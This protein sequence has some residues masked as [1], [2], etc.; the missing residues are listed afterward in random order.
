MN[1]KKTTRQRLHLK[2]KRAV[3]IGVE[4]SELYSVPYCQTHINMRRE[5]EIAALSGAV[6][7]MVQG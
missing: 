4:G 7:E 1:L 6:V 2:S 3:A 5:R